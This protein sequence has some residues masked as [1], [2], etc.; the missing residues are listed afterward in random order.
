MD[1]LGA[2][3]GLLV[4]V[5]HRHRVELAHTVFAIQYAGRVFPRHRAAGFNLSPA[6]LG[7]IALAQTTLGDEI[8]DAALA[9]CIAGIPVLDGRI[10]D[11]RI[12]HCDQFYDG[13]VQLVLIAHRRGAAFEIGHVSALL[14]DDQRALELA[15]ILRIDT[16]V[17][18]ELHWTPHALWNVN[19]CAI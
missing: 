12:F 16:E 18:A 1:H 2:G 17:G 9:L 7:S 5:G 3:I 13:R 15:G 10:F 14:G 6:D 4:I 19:E 11:L 8:I